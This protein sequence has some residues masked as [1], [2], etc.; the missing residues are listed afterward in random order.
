MPRSSAGHGR[1]S[2]EVGWVRVLHLIP[3]ATA[4]G[5][6][7]LLPS[8]VEQ[9]RRMGLDGQVVALD[10]GPLRLGRRACVARPD[11]LQGWTHRGNLAASLLRRVT[12]LRVPV[13]WNV[14]GGLAADQPPLVRAMVRLGARLSRGAD[15]IVYDSATAAREHAAAG[16]FAQRSRV[17]PNGVDAERV[18]PDPEVRA[19]LGRELGIADDVTLV[20]TLAGGDPP[21]DLPGLLRAVR[22]ALDQGPRLHLALAGVGMEEGDRGVTAA[23][24]AAGLLPHVSLLGPRAAPERLLPGLDLLVLPAAAGEAC[25]PLLGEAMA[26]GVP[27]IA[28]DQGDAAAMLGDGGRIVPPGEPEQ[29]ARAIQNFAEI[30]PAGRRELGLRARARALERFALPAIARH[31][32]ELYRELRAA[33]PLRDAA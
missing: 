30:G 4:G 3:E 5:G 9:H 17:I 25:P 21:A 7:R 19:R 20:G 6:D 1:D 2:G 33:E 32:A 26:A 28:A 23:I 27:C 24:A 13:V 22:R 10:G 14:R 16:F 11:L 15:A 8:L 31:Y 29:L 18:R 12:G